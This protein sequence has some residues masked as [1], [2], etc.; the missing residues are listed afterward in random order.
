M[1]NPTVV[2]ES[3]N[4]I[5]NIGDVHLGR[6]FKSNVLLTRRGE[7]EAKQEA[8]LQQ[9]LHKKLDASTVLLPGK[10]VIRCQVGDWFDKANVAN[11]AVL[12]SWA[13]LRN[14]EMTEQVPLY[15][16][17]GNHDDSKSLSEVT[18]WDVLATF[19]SQSNQVVFVKKWAVH[20]FPDGTQVLLVGWNISNSAAE[21]YVQAVDAGYTNIKVVVCHLDR[22]S[23]GDDSNVIPYDFFLSKGIEYVISG[24]EHK[25]Y[26]FREN[27]MQVIGTGSL[28]PYSHAE[29]PEQKHYITFRSIDEMLEHGLAS[30]IDMHVRLYTDDVASVPEVDCLSLQINKSADIG[31]LEV[32]QEVIIESY[33]AQGIWKATTDE[34]NMP[35]EASNQLWQKIQE[36]N[37]ND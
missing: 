23:Y 13:L 11:R 14:Y 35:V 1:R 24:H 4:I 9:E 15:I 8:V 7:Y 37:L 25:P 2:T 18:S 27:N 20:T 34:L 19:F 5:Q 17:S 30:L 29:D 16:I 10:G 33:S 26:M 32:A 36:N 3:G 22:V 28:L 12:T 21:A 31:E 6:I